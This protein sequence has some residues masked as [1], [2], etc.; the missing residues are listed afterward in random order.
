MRWKPISFFFPHL[1]VLLPA[2]VPPFCTLPPKKPRTPG[3]KVGHSAWMSELDAS[4]GCYSWMLYCSHNLVIREKN[5]CCLLLLPPPRKP[6]H[7]LASNLAS[8]LDK[9]HGCQSWMLVWDAIVRYYNSL[10]NWQ[11]NRQT[12]L[13]VKLAVKLANKIGSQIGSREIGKQNW[14]SK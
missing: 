14:Q 9:V 10:S 12:K 4:M 3:I 7:I 1:Y 8:K 2:A 6:S 13:A 11:R 5:T